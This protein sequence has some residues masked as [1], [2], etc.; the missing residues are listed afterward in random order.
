MPAIAHAGLPSF[1]VPAMDMGYGSN[2]EEAYSGMDLACKLSANVMRTIS[3]ALTRVAN[4]YEGQDAKNAQMFQGKAI[5]PPEVP[6][7]SGMPVNSTWGD[8]LRDTAIVVGEAGGVVSMMAVALAGLGVSSARAGG[9]AIVVPFGLFCLANI[10]DPW[11]HISA[12]GGWSEVESVLADISPD[13]QRMV[14]EVTGS[15]NWQGAGAN[16]FNSYVTNIFAPM[17]DTAKGLASDMKTSSYEAAAG[18][19]AA[20]VLF[21][22][23]TYTAIS[24]C[25]AADADPEPLSATAIIWATLE[26]WGTFIVEIVLEMVTTFILLGVAAAT[27]A[28]SYKDLHGW[29]KDENGKLDGRSASLKLADTTKI[30]DW[31]EWKK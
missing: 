28:S 14:H 17:V 9:A 27:I 7:A 2:Y 18:L 11:P 1:A 10:R 24:T 19:T 8:P 29:L 6:G 21:I 12:A 3:L 16:T 22:V 30:Q 25:V 15:A 4:H 31:N 20:L 26:M 13:L 5:P 23:A